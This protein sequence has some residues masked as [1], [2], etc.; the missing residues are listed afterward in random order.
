MDRPNPLYVAIDRPDLDGAANLARRLRGVVGGIK[1]GL[2]FWSAQG[3][4]GVRA[5]A[6]AGL[7]IFLD[8]KLHDIPNTVAASLHSLARLGVSLITLHAAG[9]MR[10]LRD[11]AAALADLPDRPRLLAVTVLTSLDA[12]D[13]RSLGIGETPSEQAIRLARL[14]RSCGIDGVVCSPLEVEAVR[15]ACGSDLLVVTPGIRPAS[16]AA[17]DQKRVTTP[18]AALR[19][20]ADLLVIGRPITQAPDPVAAARAILDSIARDG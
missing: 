15:H 11:A 3:P 8:V 7:P 20:G 14:A 13:L 10:M 17:G 2:E 16:D 4:A 19:A 18:A 5:L 12:E 9:G 6:T 1:L